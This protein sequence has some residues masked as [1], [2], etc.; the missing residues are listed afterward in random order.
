MN[1][2]TKEQQELTSEV[3]RTRGGIIASYAQIEFLLADLAVQCQRRPNLASAVE[4]FPY[5]IEARYRAVNKL[6]K[7]EPLRQYRSLAA[8]LVKAM[9]KWESLR[10]MLAHGFMMIEF[11]ADGLHRIVFRM[12]DPTGDGGANLRVFQTNLNLLVQA[13]VDA[14][15]FAQQFVLLW[16][17]IY[18][19]QHL[20][21]DV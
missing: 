7:R 6:L 13:S 9:G 20:E 21:G 11:S 19:E 3:M 18:L 1:S 5:K 12:Y 4:G 14:A 15:A 10:H 17:R 16:R 2:V 8:P